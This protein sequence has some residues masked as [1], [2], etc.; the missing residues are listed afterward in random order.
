[1]RKLILAASLLAAAA[2]ALAQTGDNAPPPIQ[3]GDDQGYYYHPGSA[4]APRAGGIDAL[5]HRVEGVADA[6]MD[7]DV[8]QVVDA[9]DPGR[10]HHART[11]GD[12]ATR[13][14]PQARQSM[15]RS[16][17][18]TTARLDATARQVA[19]VTP[20]LLR[21]LQDATRRIE[22]AMYARP[23]PQD[24]YRDSPR[25]DDRGRPEPYPSSSD[26]D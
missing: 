9:V 15:H 13:R 14:D 21:S 10:R 6:L 23:L 25:E 12:L 17:E 22:A 24:G 11:L 20:M 7:V 19:I 2:P 8:G 26:E 16:I 4:R 1:M 5:G 18:R 3:P